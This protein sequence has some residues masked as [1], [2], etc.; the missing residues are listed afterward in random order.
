MRFFKPTA[1]FWNWLT[2]H[3]GRPVIDCGCGDGE[4][5]REIRGKGMNAVGVDPRYVL[6][7]E[8]IPED[9]TN[10]ILPLPVEQAGELLGKHS[11]A[12]CC[13]PCHNGFPE[14]VATI[15]HPGCLLFYIGFP[16]NL[17]CDLGD[18]ADD[19]R[20]ILEGVGEDGELLYQ[21]P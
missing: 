5:V 21:I 4:L 11:L 1:A 18:W 3:S 16:K 10:A 7:D 15:K 8:P 17:D 6:F 13:R 19:A 14:T 2:D 9:L 12:L 20:L